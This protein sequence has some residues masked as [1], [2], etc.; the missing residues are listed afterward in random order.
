MIRIKRVK[1]IAY[2]CNHCAKV[3]PVTA[4]MIRTESQDDEY[5]MVG[6]EV[7]F[8]LCTDCMASLASK[9]LKSVRKQLKENEGCPESLESR[10][11]EFWPR[12]QPR[13]DLEEKE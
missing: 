7:T 5:L 9:L 1:G 10:N 3:K 2:P 8:W 6:W 11:L 12:S 13:T 4:T